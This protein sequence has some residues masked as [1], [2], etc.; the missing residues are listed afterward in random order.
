MVQIRVYERVLKE[1]PIKKT[2]TESSS[3][4]AM[5]S[6][7][8]ISGAGIA[9]PVLAFWL[10]KAGIRCT[11]IERAPTLPTAGQQIDVR[12]AALEIVRRMG[13]EDTIKSRSTKEQG[14]QFI[15]SDGVSQ[16]NF[17]VDTNGGESFS[18]EI[19]ILRGDLAE[20]CYLRSSM[21]LSFGTTRQ[22]AFGS[23]VGF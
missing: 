19:E 22:E 3:L 16:A 4:R 5:I 1:V 9:G 11:I 6:S 10:T 23:D 2:D 8:L 20:V 18:S 12:A 21:S 7:V 15:N 13:L 17:G 14:I